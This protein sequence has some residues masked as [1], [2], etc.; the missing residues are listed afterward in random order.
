MLK[1]FGYLC[2]GFQGISFIHPVVVV[3]GGNMILVS[4][5]FDCLRYDPFPNPRAVFG[6]KRMG[7]LVP[8]VEIADNANLLCIRSPDCKVCPLPFSCR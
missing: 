6:L 7:P 4:G 1:S 5:T 3:A 8:V 2:S